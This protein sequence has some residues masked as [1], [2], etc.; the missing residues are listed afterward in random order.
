[1]SCIRCGAYTDPD[2]NICPDCSQNPQVTVLPPEE[3]ENFQG[4]T[5]EQTTNDP[6]YDQSQA[7]HSNPHVYVRH[8]N[9][10]STKGNLLLKLFIG[11]IFLLVIVIALPLA[12]IFLA[13]FIINWFL[14]KHTS[15]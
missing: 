14:T 1:M 9:F 11:A 2:Q 15:K 5:I 7:H 3:N 6:G 4:L 8:F 12:L 10:S 13:F